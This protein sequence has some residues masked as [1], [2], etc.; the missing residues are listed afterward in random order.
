MSKTEE[1]YRTL[2]KDPD[3]EIKSGLS[4]KQAARQEAEYRARQYNNN[5]EALALATKPAES[6]INSLLDHVQV[7]KSYK[8]TALIKLSNIFGRKKKN[9]TENEVF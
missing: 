8:D 6:S 5:V 3:L 9:E 1:F 2:V 4:R 7:N